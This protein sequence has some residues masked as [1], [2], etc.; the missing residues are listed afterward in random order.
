MSV[1]DRRSTPR[2]EVLGRLHGHLVSLDVSITVGNL[3]LG[4]FSAESVMPFPLGA[5]HQFRFT[6]DRGVGIDIQAVVVHRRPG[7]SVDG[8]T[9]FVTGFSFVHDP[10]HDTARDIRALMASMTD[11]DDGGAL[12]EA[13]SVE[14]GAAR[15]PMRL[16]P[17]S[18][19]HD[20][21]APTDRTGNRA[22]APVLP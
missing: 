22:D 14:P 17:A 11:S 3:G 9:F 1:T 7:Y 13:H 10:M 8:L 12:D 15:D 16:V 6:T 19:A 21:E 18:P 2:L 4:G 20:A 5:R